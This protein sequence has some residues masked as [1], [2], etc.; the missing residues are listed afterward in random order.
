MTAGY[1]VTLNDVNARAGQ[2]ATTLRND[3]D[4]VHRY[5]A[6]IAANADG[7]FTGLGMSAP[8]LATLRASFIALDKLYQVAHALTTQTPASD[9]FF[10]AKNL[11]GVL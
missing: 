9:F 11:S 5:A 2:L 10:D 7:F 4:D 6:F 1:P 8:D 3:L